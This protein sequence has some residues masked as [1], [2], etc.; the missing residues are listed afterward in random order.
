MG[1]TNYF[2]IFFAQI[3]QLLTTHLLY[4]A[5]SRYDFPFP[6][7]RHQVSSL[8]LFVYKS[9]SPL[10]SEM[11]FIRF[12]ISLICNLYNHLTLCLAHSI[13]SINVCGIKAIGKK[14]IIQSRFRETTTI[15]LCRILEQ[16]TKNQAILWFNLTN[17]NNAYIIHLILFFSLSCTLLIPCFISESSVG[18]Y[19]FLPL[20]TPLSPICN[21]SKI[22]LHSILG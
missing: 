14:V 8:Q 21:E 4:R 22:P 15:V 7:S 16:W 9:V 3:H 17:L 2:C 18:L 20:A 13:S 11:L 6:L 12:V 10:P 19:L 1:S 5:F